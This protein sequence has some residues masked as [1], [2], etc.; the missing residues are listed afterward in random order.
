MKTKGNVRTRSRAK[1]VGDAAASPPIGKALFDPGVTETKFFL[2]NPRKT[3]RAMFK[4]YPTPFVW[5]NPVPDGD[6]IL[7]TAGMYKVNS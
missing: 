2:R 4:K 1:T 5:D 7:V 6:V 3:P